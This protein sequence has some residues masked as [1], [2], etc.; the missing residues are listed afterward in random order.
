[1]FVGAHK[2]IAYTDVCG[3]LCSTQHAVSHHTHCDRSHTHIRP[4]PRPTP[5]PTHATLLTVSPVHTEDHVI[6]PVCV[7]LHRANVG[8]E[9]RGGEGRGE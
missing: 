8:L 6:D 2:Y 7:V 4:T 3:G 9:G 5:H 1:M